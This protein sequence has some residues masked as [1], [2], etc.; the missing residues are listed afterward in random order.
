MTTELNFATRF[1]VAA[2]SAPEGF[3][4]PDNLSLLRGAEQQGYAAIPVG[5]RGGGCGVCKIRLLA[6]EIYSKPMSSAHISA[7][8]R[9]AGYV[10]AC[11]VF[12]RSDL[13]I[14]IPTTES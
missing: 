9:A 5:C 4:C 2:L 8:E 1:H 13:L 14:E 11:R 3:A 10:L 6:G 12:P 7:Q